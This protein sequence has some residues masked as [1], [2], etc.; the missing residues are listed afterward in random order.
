MLFLR[1][2]VLIVAAVV[3]GIL[4]TYRAGN[5]RVPPSPRA[6]SHRPRTSV[7]RT[8]APSRHSLSPRTGRRGPVQRPGAHF[9]SCGTTVATREDT[10]AT[11]G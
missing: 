9:R 11:L 4:L 10:G 6:T 7:M 8:G 3:L 5:R 1:L 2:A